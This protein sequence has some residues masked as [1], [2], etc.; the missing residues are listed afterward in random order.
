[1]KPSY[2][3]TTRYD[4]WMNAWAANRRANFSL[5]KRENKKDDDSRIKDITKKLSETDDETLTKKAKRILGRRLRFLQA[6]YV[7]VA[8]CNFYNEKITRSTHCKKRCHMGNHGNGYCQ[9]LK[10]NFNEWPAPKKY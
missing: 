7:G 3:T 2:D 6:F 10:P 5:G 9:Y 8:Y 4:R 1:M